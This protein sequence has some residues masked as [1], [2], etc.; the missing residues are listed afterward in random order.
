MTLPSVIL[1]LTS[2]MT[3]QPLSSLSQALEKIL[4]GFPFDFLDD[5]GTFSTFKTFKNFLL[6]FKLPVKIVISVV[7]PFS[8][9]SLLLVL[10]LRSWMSPH[11]M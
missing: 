1:C 2:H 8:L 5:G 4:V 10:F 6:F 7:P 3:V 9:R 11:V